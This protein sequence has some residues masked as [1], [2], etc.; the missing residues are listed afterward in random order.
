MGVI[1]EW[2]APYKNN[3]PAHRG[4]NRPRPRPTPRPRPGVAPAQARVLVRRLPVSSRRGRSG[5][6]RPRIARRRCRLRRRRF[7]SRRPRFRRQRFIRA[8]VCNHLDNNGVGRCPAIAPLSFIPTCIMRC[9]NRTDAAILSPTVCAKARRRG[10]KN[11]MPPL[12]DARRG[13]IWRG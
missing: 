11:P 10:G 3:D 12:S 5:I 7:A 4:R 2:D 6:R 13:A 8:G 9:W 1:G